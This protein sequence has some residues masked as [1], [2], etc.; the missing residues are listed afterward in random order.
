MGDGDNNN[1]RPDRDNA[2]MTKLTRTTS[3]VTSMT[4]ATVEMG[5]ATQTARRGTLHDERGSPNL[6]RT[7]VCHTIP[8]QSQMEERRLHDD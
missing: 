3:T 7:S 5:I 6:T 1:S 4:T 8:R 2:T